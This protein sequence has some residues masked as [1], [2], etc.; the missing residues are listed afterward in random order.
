[1][2]IKK[3]L[4]RVA[5]LRQKSTTAYATTAYICRSGKGG[6]ATER[7]KKMGLLA[8]VAFAVV[9]ER[10][11]DR[12][13][14]TPQIC[15]EPQ[16]QSSPPTRKLVPHFQLMTSLVLA[17]VGGVFAPVGGVSEPFRHMPFRPRG[18]ATERHMTNSEVKS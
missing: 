2:T 9:A 13:A 7:H 8:V 1:M 3:L 18:G 14:K 16:C 5:P 12:T 6:G 10:G 17:L 11:C 15:W 4:K